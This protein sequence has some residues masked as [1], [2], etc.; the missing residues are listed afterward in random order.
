M[1]DES[2]ERYVDGGEF[3]PLSVWGSRG[4]DADRIRDRT[5][6]SDVREDEVL[7][8]VYRVR[9]L[10]TET[11]GKRATIR[12]SIAESDRAPEIGDGMPGVEDDESSDSSSP[13]SSSSSRSRRKSKKDK[14]NKKSKKDKTHKKDK[15]SKRGRLALKASTRISLASGV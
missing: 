9:I 10:R 14:K 5:H 8:T 11:T 6:R 13:S 15:K 4:F 3:L 2:A 7:G 12:K 1:V